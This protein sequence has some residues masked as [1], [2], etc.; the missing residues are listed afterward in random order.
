MPTAYEGLSDTQIRNI[1]EMSDAL[2]NIVDRNGDESIS[3]EELGSHLLL[4]RYTEESIEALFD[5][6]DVN[7]DGELSRV[8]LRE[9]YVRYP[10]L[11]NA[12]AMGSL[13]KSKQA[14]VH[15]EADATFDELDLDGNGHLTLSELQAHFEGVE[16]PTYSKSAVE[17][18][19][20]TLDTDGN[21]EVSR[22]EFRGSYV[23]YR[24]M[25]IA[26]GLR[27]A[28]P[29]VALDAEGPF[30]VAGQH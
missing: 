21:G 17:N 22:S 5:I 15:E 29:D 11:R 7:S 26:L 1:H 24:A 16:G 27:S 2:F 25:R 18:I 28:L 8:E 30:S 13:S 6:I 23:R 10:P 14:S 9:A 4:A 19:F 12:P 3:K 20:R